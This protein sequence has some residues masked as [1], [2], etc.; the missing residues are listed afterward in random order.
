MSRPSSQAGQVSRRGLLLGAAGAAGL[1]LV[2]WGAMPPRSRQGKPDLWALQ[3]G[4][5]ALNGWIKVGADGGVALAMPR[6]EMGQGVHTALAMLVAEEMDIPLGRIQ[7]VQA[8]ADKIFG[9]VAMFV[10]SLPFHPAASE[11]GE[12]PFQI[13]AAE[14]LM[15]KVARE[16]G[17]NA[18]GGSSSVADAWEP[19][20]A[21]AATARAALLG[22]AA[23]QWKLPA[24]ELS[25]VDGVIRH[26]SGVQAH[27]G[28]LARSASATPPGVVTLKAAQNFQLLGRATPRTDVP[29]KVDGSA[30]FGLDVRLPGMVYAA[31]R[32]CPM[33]GGAPGAFDADVALR[34]PGVERVVRL[35]SY[36]GSTAGVA[37]VARGYWQ[38]QQ[39][40]R[41]LEIDW[42]PP[43]GPPLDSEAIRQR[44][45]DGAETASG[46]EFH[47]RGD[48]VAAEKA[49]ARQ[50]TARYEAPY[51]AHATLE[52]MN[53]TAQVSADGVRLWVPT[54][55]PQMAAA[56]AA[57]V[58]GVPVDKVDVNVTQLGGGF[59][60]RLEVDV[61]GQAVRIAME[62]GGRP[63]QLIWSREEDFTHDFYR[64]MQVA[65][66]QAGVS[67]DGEIQSLSV[68]S[69]GDAITP[70]WL[71]RGL[72]ALAGPM[73]TPDKTTAEGLFDQA[74]DIPNQ[75]MRHLAT[76]H[77]V[78]IG[79]WRSVGHSH[80]AFFTES[81][82]DEVASATGA[83]AVD[84]RRKLLKKSPRHL[85]VLN[86]AAEQSQ[87]GKPVAPGRARGVAIHESFGSIVAQ[88]AEVSLEGG[89]LRVH[90]V[91]CAIDC[92]QVINPTT[93]A[94]QMEGSVV[95]AL[96]AALYGEVSIKAGRVQGGNFGEHRL[97]TLEQAPEVRTHIQASVRPP[98]GV[99][100]PGVPPLAPAV[101]NAVFVL[102]G[103][104]MRQL[105]FPKKFGSL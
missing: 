2:G 80:N 36:A 89:Q 4:D 56:Q 86:L 51:L 81:F 40:V 23:A 25:I 70:R 64:P 19:V 34:L 10:A 82:I 7:L 26:P 79:F 73:D 95:F 88:V 21:A 53:C 103:Q 69:A 17:I 105:P 28:E 74:Y 35:A 97:V 1:L 104:R 13:R 39:A 32:M 15:A 98:T 50:V 102:T 14:W 57:L 66:L 101:A 22:A 29:A 6:S 100:E 99:G 62:C 92:G 72:P 24:G 54:Q 41:A 65:W 49:A 76:H 43:V 83:D 93:V 61:V 16:L 5:V 96:S 63:V 68:A 12:P 9:N 94:Q 87:W 3:E 78:P 20:R 77:R 31:I 75:S 60:R 59:G 42:R 85:A 91:T 71:E 18:T 11:G 37:V 90:R 30:L 84:F 44:L 52:P 67:A 33:L 46:F 58:A 27:F 38:A 48:V 47:A 8:G 55:V 45:R